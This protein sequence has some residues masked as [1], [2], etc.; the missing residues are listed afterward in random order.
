MSKSI[1][2]AL[3]Y[4]VHESGVTRLK[5]MSIHA[6]N[7]YSRSYLMSDSIDKNGFPNDVIQDSISH[8]V[9][10]V[11]QY[12]VATLINITLVFPSMRVD[13]KSIVGNTYVRLI[14]FFSC[15]II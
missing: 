2:L 15:R 4:R 11:T 6:K 9:F 14:K 12:T 1:P 3:A 8:R 10:M 5:I 13:A 7:G